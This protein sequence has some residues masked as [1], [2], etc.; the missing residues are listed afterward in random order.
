M[1]DL[2]AGN[3]GRNLR[4]GFTTG[5]SAAAAA[6]AALLMLFEGGEIHNMT[7]QTPKGHLFVAEVTD[8]QRD[9]EARTVSCAVTKDLGDD[10]DVT[11]GL[12]IFAKVSLE[13]ASEG[14]DAKKGIS[15][16]GGEGIGI[17]TRPGLPMPVGS[18]AIYPISREMIRGCLEEV[19]SH[20]YVIDRRVR[21][22]IS[23]PDAVD[24]AERFYTPGQGIEG[25]VSILGN[26]GIV[27]PLSDEMLLYSI[28][29]EI[30]MRKTMGEK[31]LVLS[32][33]GC[34]VK[35]ISDKYAI[36]GDLAV[37]C[38]NQVYRAVMYAMEAGFDKILVIG[39]MGKLA[40][41]SAGVKDTHQSLGDRRMEI[42]AEIT[43]LYMK[44]STPL[45]LLDNI[46]TSRDFD[47][48]VRIITEAGLKREVF[49]EMAVRIK[50]H[51]EDWTDG[52][53]QVETV[54]FNNDQSE[55]MPSLGAK[56]L[57]GILASKRERE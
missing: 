24:V 42:I 8:I 12:K 55:L 48:T 23:A 44:K 11:D 53:V 32:P 43:S 19:L 5:G 10:S 45:E 52:T 6:K 20:N 16:Q 50:R 46:R 15:I 34:G 39:R 21:V 30:V 38:Y 29:S 35:Y 3:I 28:R 27:E 17:V 56:E 18:P 26:T 1:N 4:S 37:L 14:E 40:K 41:V 54:L 13:D 9:A 47:D 7:V 22:E 36:S 31:V 2:Y 51:M 57:L 49:A 25:G 33:Y